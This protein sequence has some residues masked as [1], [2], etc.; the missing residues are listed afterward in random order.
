MTYEIVSMK[1]VNKKFSGKTALENI[2]FS[3]LKGEIFGF[4][5]PSGS[6]KTTTINILTGQLAQDSGEAYLLGKAVSELGRTEFSNMGIVSDTS[7][8]YEKMTVYK[9]LLIYAKIHGVLAIEITNLLQNVG[10]LEHQN[11][12]AS[13]LSTGMRQRMLLARAMIN[14]PHILFLDEPTSGLDP[15]T[16]KK[17]H[18]LLLELQKQGT[19]IFLTTH[20]MEEATLLCNEIVLLNKGILIESGNPKEL[21]AKYTQES[22]VIITNDV[23]KQTTVP[24]KKES[25]DKYCLDDTFSIHSCEPT[26]SQIFIRLTGD[27]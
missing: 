22:L 15:Y 8:F 7:G 12:L 23:G 13:E 5:G 3:I 24:F 9:N 25:L 19:T 1:K 27:K 14:R 11:K 26:L 18:Q 6:G 4:L 20:D 21:I 17:I 10:L 2:S 16:S